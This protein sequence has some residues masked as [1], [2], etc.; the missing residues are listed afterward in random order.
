MRLYLAA[1]AAQG[2]EHG[3]VTAGFGDEFALHLAVL[4]AQQGE[5]VVPLLSPW[6]LVALAAVLV[7][8]GLL[9]VR[10]L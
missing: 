10:R 6:A 4:V 5:T 9:A 2:A 3:A 8:L 1:Q 7:V